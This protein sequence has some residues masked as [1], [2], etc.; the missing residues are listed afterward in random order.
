MPEIASRHRRA[1]SDVELLEAARTGEAGSLHRLWP[2]HVAAVESYASTCVSSPAEIPELASFAYRALHRRV[3]EADGLGGR[4][5]DGCVR[6]QLLQLVRARAVQTGASGPPHPTLFHLW[7]HS[8]AV[9]PMRDDWQLSEAFDRLGP[10][11]KTLLWHCL[12]ERDSVA[13]IAEITGVAVEAVTRRLR[14]ARS[15]LRQSRMRI[16]LAHRGCGDCLRP[17]GGVGALVHGTGTPPSVHDLTLCQDCQKVYG[18]LLHLDDWLAGQLPVRILGWWP[19]DEYLRAKAVLRQKA[20]AASATA[21]RRARGS[22]RH[23][24]KERGR[25]SGR[26]RHAAPPMSGRMGWALSV[27]AGTFSGGTGKRRLNGS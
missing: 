22:A 23:V 17:V 16:H 24:R 6:L 5:H 20:T 27:A 13:D 12:V 19:G 4:R 21:L 18:D 7:V 2:R 8:G 14:L 1:S 26:A 15:H 11:D 25:R 10:V 3:E 9:W